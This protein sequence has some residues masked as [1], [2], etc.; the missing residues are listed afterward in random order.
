MLTSLLRNC[1]QPIAFPSERTRQPTSAERRSFYV[2]EMV[3]AED[4]GSEVVRNVHILPKYGVTTHPEDRDLIC[5]ADRLV[6]GYITT[7]YQQLTN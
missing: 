4:G 3:R 2:P 7:L 6:M 5:S 1:A